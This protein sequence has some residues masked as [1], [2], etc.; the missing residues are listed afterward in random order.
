MASMWRTRAFAGLAVG[1][2]V[3]VGCG[4]G[5]TDASPGAEVG[6]V[7]ALGEGDLEDG[8][9]EG[10]GLVGAGGE[11]EGSSDDGAVEEGSGSGETGAADETGAAQEPGVEDPYAIPE[12]GIDEA[13]VEKVLEAIFEVNREALN[14]TLESEP[15]LLPAAAEDRL[16]SIYRGAYGARQYA[17]L[18][19]IARDVDARAVFRGK[20]GAL[21]VEVAQLVA[22]EPTCVVVERIAD[23]QA[24]LVDPPPVRRDFVVLA[25][26]PDG[27]QDRTLNPTPWALADAAIDEPEA[28]SC[29]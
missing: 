23:F 2:L 14:L 7:D 8:D 3:L 24:V 27:D 28:L 21:Q 13:Y 10:D 5:D 22:V 19:E 4:D 9:P 6:P 26:R 29:D 18:N 1:V 15:G 17:S 20:P 16:R 12:D 11:T 25:L